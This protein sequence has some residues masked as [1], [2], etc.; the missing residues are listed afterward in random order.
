MLRTILFFPHVIWWA[1]SLHSHG[2]KRITL[3]YPLKDSWFFR[4]VESTSI[5]TILGNIVNIGHRLR[6]QLGFQYNLNLAHGSGQDHR[7]VV[8]VDTGRIDPV[9]L[10]IAVGTVSLK[11]MCIGVGNSVEPLANIFWTMTG[12]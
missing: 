6:R 10:N 1:F 8:G 12:I 7:S 9:V 2:R 11:S 3:D 5:A 4:P